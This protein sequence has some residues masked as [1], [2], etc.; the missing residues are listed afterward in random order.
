MEPDNGMHQ[1]NLAPSRLDMNGCLL[2]IP[3]DKVVAA[4]TYLQLVQ[5]DGC[6]AFGI[7]KANFMLRI[8][9]TLSVIVSN[10]FRK[11]VRDEGSKESEED[12]EDEAADQESAAADDV[13]AHLGG[14]RAV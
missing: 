7:L 5:I 12:A 1:E 14:T 8:V 10:A 4:C 6:A 11:P 9:S 2:P 3:T 13:A